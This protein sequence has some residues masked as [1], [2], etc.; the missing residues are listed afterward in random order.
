MQ[1]SSLETPS[2]S[3][4]AEAL[5]FAVNDLLALPPLKNVVNFIRDGFPIGITGVPLLHITRCLSLSGPPKEHTAESVYR[6]V[7][8]LVLSLRGSAGVLY[9]AVL[10]H[11]LPLGDAGIATLAKLADPAVM[12]G[13]GF[14]NCDVGEEGIEHLRYRLTACDG[15]PVLRSL[16]I[17]C[18]NIGDASVSFYAFCI[19]CPYYNSFD[20][21]L[22]HSFPL[23]LIPKCL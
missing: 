10:A 1:S 12:T 19:L 8:A 9:D 13:I 15:T 3:D 14:A 5:Y 16:N 17:S 4:A 6:L 21:R 23:L 7:V 22:P 18:N 2:A 11:S 20:S